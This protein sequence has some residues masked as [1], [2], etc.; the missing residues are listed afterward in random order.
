VL[1]EVIYLVE[2]PI[3]LEGTFDEEFHRIPEAVLVTAMQSHQRYFPLVGNRFAFVANGGDPDVVRAGNELVLEGRLD[4]AVFTFD[5]DV[6]VG[7]DAL[8]GRLEAITFFAGAG[9]LA[10]KTERLKRLAERLGGGDA[11]IEA[12]R[13][14]K[15]DQASELVREFPELEGVIGAEYARLAGYPEAV[16][17]AIEEQYLPESAT[18]PLPRTEAGKVL[19]AADRIDTLVVSLGLGQKP[20]GSRDPYGLRRAA[21]GL[22]RLATEGGLE[23]NRGLLPDEVREFVEERFE[24]MLDVPVEAVRAAVRSPLS[25][26]GSVAALAKFLAE[27]DNAA[28]DP[29]H[30]AFTRVQRIAGTSEPGPVDPGLLVEPTERELAEAV[31][32]AEARI[33][34]AVAERRF[35]DA[36]AGATALAPV[37]DRFFDDVLVMDEDSAVRANRLRLLLA[38]RDVIRALGDLSQIPR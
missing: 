6:A 30:T 25:D 36:L 9:T 32:R 2:S 8:A 10:E 7:I 28:L 37:V 14:A 20:T 16:C 15:A 5:R 31:E 1:E 24:S 26:L 38:V 35:D 12:A 22:C 4:D 23:I 19:A 27:L 11:S 18:G 29:V 33:A 34:P 21:I 13:L 17:A 3:L